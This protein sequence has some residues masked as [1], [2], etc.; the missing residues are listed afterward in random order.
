VYAVI[1]YKVL[2]TVELLA[3][4]KNSSVK[5]FASLSKEALRKA[6][7]RQQKS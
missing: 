7:L 2:T 6:G 4:I 3:L 1:A 5:F